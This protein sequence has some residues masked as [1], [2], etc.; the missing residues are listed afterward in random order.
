MKAFVSWSGGKDC[1]LAMHRF[2]KDKENTVSHLVNMCESDKE[3]SRSHGIRN[4]WIKSQAN[5][6]GIELIQEKIGSSYEE[7]FKKVIS[8]LKD[9]GVAAGVFGDIYLEEHKVWIDHVCSDMGIEAIFPLWGNTTKD[10]LK[11][12]ITEGFKTLV[13]AIDNTKLNRDWLGRVID[14][15]FYDDIIKLENIDPCAE[16]GEYHTFVYDGPI[17]NKPI[18]FKVGNEIIKKQNTYLELR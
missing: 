18:D 4:T 5:S 16:K 6:I 17:F 11:E 15:K 3:Y 7:S 1:M 12:F 9:K 14:H 13:V 8:E 10:L 2:L